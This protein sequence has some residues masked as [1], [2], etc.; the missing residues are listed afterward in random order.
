MSDAVKHPDHYN[1]VP[2]VEC[3]QVVQHFNFNLGNAIKYIW[4]SGHKGKAVED[5]RKAIQ[6]LEFEI[7]RM[8]GSAPAH[9]YAHLA[10]DS[11]QG[12]A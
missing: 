5:L 9:P 10:P 11:A 7:E 6:Y 3:I 12:D 1:R 2:G 8:G 4:R